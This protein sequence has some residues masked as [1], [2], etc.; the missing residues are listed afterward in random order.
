MTNIKI[1]THMPTT[2]VSPA[3]TQSTKKKVAQQ[4]SKQTHKAD[5]SSSKGDINLSR[6]NRAQAK[7]QNGQS[8]SDKKTPNTFSV[9]LKDA[10]STEVSLSAPNDSL[11]VQLTDQVTGEYQDYLPLIK[12]YRKAMNE[13]EELLTRIETSRSFAILFRKYPKIVIPAGFFIVLIASLSFNPIFFAIAV[14]SAINP[15]S[16][17]FMW[18]QFGDL[19]KFLE[20]REKMLLQ[21]S[22]NSAPR[23]WEYL[24]RNPL[25]GNHYMNRY[26]Q[27]IYSAL[28]NGIHSQEYL[29]TYGSWHEGKLE[30]RIAIKTMIEQ[31]ESFY[32]QNSAGINESIKNQQ[33]SSIMDTFVRDHLHPIL[34]EAELLISTYRAKTQ[35]SF[36]SY[37]N[38]QKGATNLSRNYE[39][40]FTD[41]NNTMREKTAEGFNPVIR[42]LDSV[43]LAH[44]SNTNTARKIQQD[45]NKFGKQLEQ[46][47]PNSSSTTPNSLTNH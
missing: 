17:E 2:Q 38:K 35:S 43:F 15:E 18:R 39:K 44:R 22:I 29:K 28:Q 9:T 42:A 25:F 13:M 20:Y 34:T 26:Q 31:A 6:I 27:G 4:P 7:N 30:K 36:D 23:P 14:Y 41:H 32:A 37:A 5:A 1:S 3:R 45:A 21:A 19:M 11:Q 24:F 47:L 10:Q 33:Q 8:Q 40:S 46:Q 16:N 12:N